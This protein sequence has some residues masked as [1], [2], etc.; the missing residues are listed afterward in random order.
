MLFI[1]SMSDIAI[2]SQI[3]VRKTFFDG[4]TASDHKTLFAMCGIPGAGK[5]TFVRQRAEEGDFPLNA[6]LLNPDKV[7]KILPEYIHDYNKDGA[8]KAFET[9]EMPAR[10]LAYAMFREALLKGFNIV[11]DMGCVREEDFENILACKKQGYHVHMHYIYCHPAEAR[12]RIK[13]RMRYTPLSMLEQRQAMLEELL[14]KYK[15]IADKF[16]MFDN[17]D[18]ESPFQMMVQDIKK[19]V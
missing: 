12:A 4:L 19:A 3:L 10:T 18:V 11:I 14:P 5:S 17:S 1:S 16:L 7:M 2:P 6:F 15:T 9:W 13:T 8:E